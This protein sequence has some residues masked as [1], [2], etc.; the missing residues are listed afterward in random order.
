[1]FFPAYERLF[2][3][4]L[5]RS[6]QRFFIASESRLRPSGVS[7]PRFLAGVA[8]GNWFGLVVLTETLL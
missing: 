8:F 5:F 6:A 1:V 7:P 2:C 3:P 4:F